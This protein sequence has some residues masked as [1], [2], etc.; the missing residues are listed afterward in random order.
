MRN[1]VCTDGD[2]IYF[3]RHITLKGPYP[4]TARSFFVYFLSYVMLA[5]VIAG[6]RLLCQ[7]QCNKAFSK[8]TQFT[9]P[10]AAATECRNCLEQ[11]TSP[12]LHQLLGGGGRDV[13]INATWQR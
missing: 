11:P 9:N 12:A 10:S 8:P 7:H 5:S 6:C 1:G 13:E 4:N 2:L 3:L